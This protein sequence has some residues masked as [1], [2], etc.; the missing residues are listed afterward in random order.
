MSDSD[1]STANLNKRLSR[2]ARSLRL[3]PLVKWSF[4]VLENLRSQL[5]TMKERI[6][7]KV[8]EA[9]IKKRES[10]NSVTEVIRVWEKQ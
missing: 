6:T 9:E 2:H 1:F 7:N 5:V 4:I 3:V 8:C 10:E